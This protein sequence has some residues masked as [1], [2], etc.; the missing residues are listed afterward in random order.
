MGL[1]IVKAMAIDA[2]MVA[3]YGADA[4]RVE[5]ESVHGNRFRFSE[6]V[7]RSYEGSES[8]WAARDEH[9]R[10]WAIAGVTES[11]WPGIG[12]PWLIGTEK[13]REVHGAW[14]A[15]NAKRLVD[16]M[17][18]RGFHVL[19]NFADPRNEAHMR[20][21]R[22][23]GFSLLPPTTK[24]ARDGAPFVGFIKVNALV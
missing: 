14:I 6:A 20:F 1:E 17:H 11:A 19:M 2:E 22:W 13:F 3:L 23:A 10:A 18:A 5:S 7:M 8:V 21:L 12:I 16:E 4:D 15:R 24:F 9:R